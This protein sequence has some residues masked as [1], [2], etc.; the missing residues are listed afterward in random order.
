MKTKVIGS[1]KNLIDLH[2][3]SPE[4]LQG[5]ELKLNPYEM[6]EQIHYRLKERIIKYSISIQRERTKEKKEIE[7]KIKELKEGLEIE[8]IRQEERL[9]KQ[10]R[11][12][13]KETALEK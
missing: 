5:I 2:K 1:K 6:M 7:T 3:L 4:E 10:S 9:Q 13:G 8:T 12:A 11:L